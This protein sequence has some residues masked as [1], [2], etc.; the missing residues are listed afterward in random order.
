MMTSVDGFFEGPD[1]DL[2]WHNA[3]AEFND[4]VI[5]QARG[6]D[7]ILFGRKTYEMMADFWPSEYARKT[8]PEVAEIMNATP[9]IVVSK[10]LARA[11]W[12]NTRLI[13][14]E[15]VKNIAELKRRPGK[16]IAIFGSNNLC[17]SLIP[18][19][20]IDE[21]RI[22]INPVALGRGSPLFAG[23]RERSDLKLIKA[24]EFRSGNVLLCYKPAN[25]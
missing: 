25:I 21:F 6:I 20:L 22:M 14:G 19:S 15:I 10:T 7:L 17:V 3:D 5:E 11:D 13:S 24:R 1:H 12:N 18:E 4:F 2:S 23:L 9:K 16:D 8:D